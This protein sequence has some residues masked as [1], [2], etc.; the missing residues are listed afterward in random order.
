M[1]DRYCLACHDNPVT[2][3]FTCSDCA[4]WYH[5]HLVHLPDLARDLDIEITRQGRKGG[6]GG[7]GGRS[8]N[9]D[10]PLEFNQAASDALG[11]LRV[12]LVSTCLTLA[13]GQRLPADT[14]DAMV[15]WLIVNEGAVQ[16]RPEAGDMMNGLDAAFK[17]GR[18]VI[19]NPPER[20]Y[21]GNCGCG[22]ELRADR[23]VGH[24]QCQGCGSTWMTQDVV[25]HRNQVARDQ[26]LTIPEIAVLSGVPRGTLHSWAKRSGR[27]AQSGTDREQQELYRY[28]DVL[29]MKEQTKRK[30]SA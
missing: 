12:V 22:A 1:T 25:D 27:L 19:D 24:V 29:D 15:E 17:H 21:L 18:R 26:L 9:F 3:T 30:A 2:D 7:D 6:S 5:Y 28:G 20:V 13:L 16:L 10:R 4:A 8:R 23:G 14:I 11:Q